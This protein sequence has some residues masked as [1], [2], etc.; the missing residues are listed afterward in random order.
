MASSS[1][2]ITVGEKK[3]DVFLSF[4]GEDTRSTFTSTLHGVL[5][6]FGINVFIDYELNRGEN[7][8]PS[9]ENAIEESKISVIIFS[10]GYASSRWCLEELV[11]IL[12][13]KKTQKEVVIPVF[14]H[15]DPSHVR[16]QTGTFG[17][18]L[19]KLVE[20]F[21][22]EKL[23][24]LQITEEQLKDKV[25]KWRNALTEAANLSGWTSQ[26]EPHDYP[27]AQKVCKDILETLNIM[28]PCV[29]KNLVGI[30][31][32]ILKI[33]DLMRIGLR[34]VL[35]VGIWG[36]RGIGKTTIAI[37]VF[38]K[39]RCHFDGSYFARN[40]WEESLSPNGLSQIRQELLST[41]LRQSDF[42][43]NSSFTKKRLG[44]KKVLIVFDDVTSLSEVEYLIE[45]INCLA[46]KSRII[47]TTT[48]KQV[49]YNCGVDDNNVYKMEGLSHNE[50]LQLFSWYAFRQN[51]PSLD[52]GDLSNRVIEYAKGV[53]LAL[54]V[55][56]CYLLGKPKQFWENAINK[57]KIIP[58]EDIHKI[59]KISYDGLNDD[60]QNIFLD[61]ACFLKWEN[62]DFVIDFLDACDFEADIGLSVLIDK[63]LIIISEDNKITMHDL[64]QEMGWE[65]V[66]QESTK[67]P[68]KRSRLW[69]HKD[70]HNV[71]EKNKISYAIEGICLDMSKREEIIYLPPNALRRM[72][73][74]RFFKLHN[75]QYEE[76]NI[77]KVH[78]SQGLNSIST[79]LRYIGWH[80]CPLKS[81]QSNFWPRYLVALD[82]PYSNIEQLWSG[83]Q[84]HNL[85]HI[86]LSY[87]KY[88]K[89]QDLSLAPNLKNLILQGC[90]SLYE[91]SSSI[92]GLN[93]KFLILNLKHCK[94]LSSLP[95]GISL[96]S[97]IKVIFSG[98]SNLKKFPQISWNIKW[99]YLDETAIEELPLSI[100]NLSGLVVLNLKD[101]SMLERLPSDI[102]KLKS[103]K[104]LNL[105]GCL[106]LH[107]LPDELGNLESLTVLRAER[108]ATREVPTSI[109]N[110]RCLEELDL[111]NCCIKELLDNL[112]QLSSLKR[113]LLGRNFFQSIPESIVELSK[114]SYL[115]LSYCERLQILP[116]LPSKLAIINA[117]NC[118]ALRGLTILSS[119][120]GR[121]FPQCVS[122]NFGNCF[123]LDQNACSKTIEDILLKRRFTREKAPPSDSGCICFPGSEIPGWLICQSVGSIITLEQPKSPYFDDTGALFFGVVVEFRNF[124]NKS[125]GLE[126]G[127]ECMLTSKDG[128]TESFH[129]SLRFWN[130]G[131]RPDYVD[132]DHVFL[133][134]GPATELSKSLWQNIFHKKYC[135]MTIRFYVEDLIPGRVD[136][137]P[138]KKCGVWCP[139]LQLMTREEKPESKRLKGS[140]FYGGESSSW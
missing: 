51:R 27:L 34:K 44:R 50:A 88:L 128:E 112:G 25:Q 95:T 120:F 6:S 2:S 59:L 63:C 78:L 70:I 103:L 41:I 38:N 126:V 79:E 26:E 10:E 43:M 57:L 30:E 105:S 82:M 121:R 116:K 137:Y 107:G 87:S 91:I 89:V 130:C 139:N 29:N 65:I 24:K 53:P 101:C 58:H 129:V 5:N 140:S 81:L 20:S 45:D 109:L 108:V 19:A 86:D 84:L 42:V 99:L 114:L 28:A 9:L 3:Y 138:V 77:N 47:I 32:I 14:Y 16:N 122:F 33:E 134:Y 133:G 36:M 100:K 7:I 90:T 11:K 132:S 69:Y 35:V 83:V 119:P 54:K 64:L 66:R 61:I 102:C 13:C 52:Y 135:E 93:Y 49:L 125:Q 115:D 56:G 21:N 31:P 39:I 23:K 8:S 113:L 55:L 136:F 60:Q 75:S 123:K 106:K 124:H 104:H 4:R 17:D 74:L 12:E 97:L 68:G 37:S 40:V 98:C 1:S 22:K 127:C 94:S 92:H 118:T 96:K 46:P 71:L 111:T 110:L 62:K 18:G 48:D 76:N 73:Q 72:H 15:I 85:K 67:D 117:H 131:T 80:G